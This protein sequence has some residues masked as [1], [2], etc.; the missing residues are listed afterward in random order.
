M[1][2]AASSSAK[3]GNNGRQKPCEYLNKRALCSALELI[4][5]LVSLI[6]ESPAI[7]FL[8]RL[9]KYWP[10]DFVSEN[11]KQFEYTV[12]EFMSGKILYGNIV[13]P[14]DLEKLERDLS[15]RIEK[16]HVDF[17]QEYRI[18]TK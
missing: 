18:L 1:T 17:S 13:H 12:E 5:E 16:N 4:K 3:F 6:N 14:D 9:E 7:I 10:V 8:W 11:I 2:R 15:I